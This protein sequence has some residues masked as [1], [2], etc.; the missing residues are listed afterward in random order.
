MKKKQS[1]QQEEKL[2]VYVVMIVRKLMIKSEFVDQIF[3]TKDAALEYAD[4]LGAKLGSIYP[5]KA[6]VE[7]E[8]IYV[9]ER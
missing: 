4:K 2:I 7:V 1:K 5:D 9:N 8:G 6:T 3:L